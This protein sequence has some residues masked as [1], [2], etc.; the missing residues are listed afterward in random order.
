MTEMEQ[1]STMVQEKKKTLS[2]TKNKLSSLNI[3]SSETVAS[4][5]KW[6]ANDKNTSFPENKT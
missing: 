6:G 4:N 2:V 3:T 5:H 1:F